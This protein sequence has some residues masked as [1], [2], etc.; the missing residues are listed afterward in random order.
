M[1]VS[2]RLE[3]L[4]ESPPSRS[5]SATFIPGAGRGREAECPYR[6]CPRTG[7]LK[8]PKE[9]T[10]AGQMTGLSPV[11]SASSN[12]VCPTAHLAQPCALAFEARRRPTRGSLGSDLRSSVV[13]NSLSDS[14]LQRLTRGSAMVHQLLAS[15]R[16]TPS[17]G[18]RKL[19]RSGLPVEARPLGSHLRSLVVHNPLSHS[20]LGRFRRSSASIHQLLVF[21]RALQGPAE[22]PVATVPQVQKPKIEGQAP[23]Q[24]PRTSN[25]ARRH[26]YHRSPA[27]PGR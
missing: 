27:A 6:R 15:Q 24:K 17:T 26:C 12:S 9:T 22:R 18:E 1:F 3:P 16:V 19:P 25:S 7:K 10:T 23:Q 21:A 13:Q 20:D 14:H 2:K 5:Q 11:P 4:A 8:R